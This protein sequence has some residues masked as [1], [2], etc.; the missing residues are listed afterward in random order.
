MEVDLIPSSSFMS[1][2]FHFERG[3]LLHAWRLSSWQ[4][5]GGEYGGIPWVVVD[6]A[7]LLLELRP[8]LQNKGRWCYIITGLHALPETVWL[9]KRGISSGEEKI[10]YLKD[11][12][13][14]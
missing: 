13:L 1:C 9:P 3:L 14:L 6:E 8:L 2:S 4:A 12:L 7:L 11:L 10:L 5:A